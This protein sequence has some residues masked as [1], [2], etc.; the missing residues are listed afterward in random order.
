MECYSSIQLNT[1]GSCCSYPRHR[2]T[3]ILGTKPPS[4]NFPGLP[5]NLTKPDVLR[6]RNCGVEIGAHQPKIRCLTCPLPYS[7]A[8]CHLSGRMTAGHSFEHR[9]E[10]IP[11]QQQQEL[12]AAT[13]VYSNLPP[14]PASKSAVPP[15]VRARKPVA[16]APNLLRTIS[17]PEEGLIPLDSLSLQSS[18]T[19]GP[20]DS[21]PLQRSIEATTSPSLVSL[22]LSEAASDSTASLSITHAHSRS[23]S[24]TPAMEGNKSE[25]ERPL[26]AS[27][28]KTSRLKSLLNDSK[29]NVSPKMGVPTTLEWTMIGN[30]NGQF[31]DLARQL[32]KVI[33]NYVDDTYFP[34][35]AGELS[36][37]KFIYS[38]C[39]WLPGALKQEVFDRAAPLIEVRHSSWRSNVTGRYQELISCS[40][41][42]LLKDC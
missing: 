36:A 2:Q 39:F 22:S 23:G 6:C 20:A 4:I 24:F 9:F 1:S 35:A 26:L 27:R 16:A 31:S 28:P 33:F 32:I 29:T 7:C 8:N 10:V 38:R 41:P 40:L 21:S 13:P 18:K 12:S 3:T 19:W 11:P 30:E 5:Q 42:Q 34:C 37:E 25:K 15:Q 17:L 14:V